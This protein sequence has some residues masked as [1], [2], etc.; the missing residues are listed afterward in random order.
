M[1]SRRVSALSKGVSPLGG[2]R[3]GREAT[4]AV[5]SP[6]SRSTSRALRAVDLIGSREMPKPPYTWPSMSEGEREARRE[7][8]DARLKA[9]NERLD[10]LFA[11]KSP[12]GASL[13]ERVHELE[14][15]VVT[16]RRFLL[17]VSLQAS[18][19]RKQALEQLDRA[20]DQ[21]D[22]IEEPEPGVR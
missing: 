18:T 3:H 2:D 12:I 22:Q 14:R 8:A 9:V 7:E 16:L 1:P 15:Q 6:P 10:R 20:L 11:P 19:S 13:E 21:I 17:L 4:A 5:L